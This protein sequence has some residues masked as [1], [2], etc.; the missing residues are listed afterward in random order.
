[1]EKENKPEEFRK[2]VVEYYATKYNRASSQVLFVYELTKSLKL[3]LEFEE[4]Y[5]DAFWYFYGIPGDL[6]EF[7]LAMAR[8]RLYRFIDKL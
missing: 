8:Y 7:N 3:Y 2:E 5:K 1:M 6:N 4:A